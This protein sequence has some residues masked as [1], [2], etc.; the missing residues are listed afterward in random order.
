MF[1]ECF[2]WRPSLGCEIEAVT[3]IEC[4]EHFVNPIEEIDKIISISKNVIFTTEL[5]PSP[6]PNPYDWWYY[7]LERGS[8]FFYS[9]QTLKYIASMYKLNYFNLNNFHI[10][11]EK[12][13]FRILN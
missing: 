5:L 7:S 12:I 3:A 1:S 13:I 4:F 2:E 8:Y 6:I 10:F 9:T 11:T